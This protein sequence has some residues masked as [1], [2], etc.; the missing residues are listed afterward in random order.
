MP[1]EKQFYIYILTNNSLTFYVGVTNNLLRRVDEHKNKANPKSFTS[2]YNINKL[3]YYEVA[4]TSYSAIVREKQ[5]K[6]MSREENIELIKSKNH[7]LRDLLPEVQS[8]LA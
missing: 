8:L 1:F 2:K 3:I 7:Q 6:N 4:E 5:I